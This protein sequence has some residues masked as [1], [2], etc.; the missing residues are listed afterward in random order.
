MNT[1]TLKWAPRILTI[2]FI[3]FI[4][5]FAFDTPI[6]SIGFWI[7]LTPSYLLTGLL[8]LAWKKPK[9]GGIAF[10]ILTVIFTFW[11]DL[12]K[13][14]IVFLLIGLPPL[15]TGVLFLIDSKTRKQPTSTD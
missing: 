15:I 3:C 14:I 6:T 12:Y 1:K 8:I 7:H 4:S 11:F 13:D 5:M 2:A 10:L 9:I